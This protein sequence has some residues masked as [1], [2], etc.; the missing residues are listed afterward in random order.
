MCSPTLVI[1]AASTA[2]GAY[3]QIQQGKA[4]AAVTKQNAA[5]AQAIG[6][7]NAGITEQNAELQKRASDDAI[8]RGAQ[9]AAKIRENARAANA[10]GR[11]IQGS[12]GLLTDTGTNLDLL[13]QNAEYGELEALTAFNN[14]EKES[15]GYKVQETNLLNQAKNIRYQGELGVQTAAMEAKNQTTAGYMSAGSTLITGASNY[16]KAG[17]FESSTYK[18]GWQWK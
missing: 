10:R 18:N 6:E 15:Y 8:A 3:S 7:Y 9:S 12:S 1:V 4:Q 2:F 16:Q 11:A 13:G 14:A 17:G 5:N